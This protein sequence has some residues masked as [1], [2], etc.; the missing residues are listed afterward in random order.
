MKSK[1]SKGVFQSYNNKT[2]RWVK[3]KVTSKGSK[4]QNVK[5]RN[6]TKKFKNVEVR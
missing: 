3:Y 1:K 4:I 2:D 5:K 6:P